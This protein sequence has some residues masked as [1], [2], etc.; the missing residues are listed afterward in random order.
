MNRDL[1]IFAKVENPAII[2]IVGGARIYYGA[3][4]TIRL[5]LP[6]CK[7]IWIWPDTP[8]NLN[9]NNF[10]CGKLFDLSATYSKSTIDIFRSLGFDM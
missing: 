1:V 8:L 4:T 9:A 6:N 5:I 10:Q 3:L 2:F 7:L